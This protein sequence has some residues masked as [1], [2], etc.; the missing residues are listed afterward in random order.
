M[1]NELVA[2]S[3]W[4][5]LLVE[6]CKAI[7]TEAVHNSRWILVE[8]YH[9][10]GERI[11]TDTNYQEYA[12]GNQHSLQLLAMR[13]KLGERTAYYAIK[14]YKKYPVLNDVPEG[15]NISWSKLVKTYL[16]EHTEKEKKT[17]YQ[18]IF[19]GIERWSKSIEG[20]VNPDIYCR[21]S[22]YV[23]EILNLLSVAEKQNDLGMISSVEA[24]ELSGE[25]ATQYLDLED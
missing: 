22:N 17:E 16:P 6:D 7:V 11:V 13:I 25:L 10:L 12:K 2:L 3:E 14:F 20:I 5:R 15:K 18:R 9:M 8:G 1:N 4:Y 21:I 23:L 19:K 24:L